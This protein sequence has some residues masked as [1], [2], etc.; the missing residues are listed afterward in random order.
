[1]RDQRGATEWPLLFL[2]SFVVTSIV[3]C[4]VVV[5]SQLSLQRRDVEEAGLAKIATAIDKLAKRVPAKGEA[6]CAKKDGC[7]QAYPKV[8]CGEYRDRNGRH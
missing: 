2:T 3:L 5:L 6:A 7:P 8:R 4:C 1:M